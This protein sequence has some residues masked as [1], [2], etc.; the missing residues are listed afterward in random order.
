[1]ALRVHFTSDDLARTRL[2]EGPRPLLELGSA[3]RLLQKTTQ[4]VGLDAWRHRA[5][6]SLNPRVRM[7]F[8]LIPKKGYSAP[9]LTPVDDGSPVVLLEE[10]RRTAPAN[11]R[12][13]L[14]GW[15]EHQPKVPAWI[16]RLGK[17]PQAL[18]GLVDML[19]HTYDELVS[20]YWPQIARL[21][22]AD[23]VVRI[24]HLAE[25]GVEGLLN[26][27]N[28]RIIRWNPPVLELTL[29]SGHSRDVH[30]NGRGL[31]LIPSFFEGSFPA[32]DDREGSQ[33][34]IIFPM[35]HGEHMRI[36][37]PAIAATLT[38]APRSLTA[39]LGRTR[40][41]VLCAIADHPGC[42]TTELARHAGVA[43]ASAS[44]HATVL[45]T[46]G[47]TTTS[48]HRNAVLHALTPAGITLLNASTASPRGCA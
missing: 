34:W 6:I 25:D 3:I 37:S 7:L 17:E 45:R 24:R 8:D 18:Q 13:D 4:T 46:A 23:R 42:T 12:D 26:S 33:P 47:L 1:M 28:P 44:E 9:F 27:L 29:A 10:V 48:R 31:L 2:A 43:P 39:L 40:A 20:P 11:L 22:L 32:M 41:T 14:Q 30:L 36:P 16:H 38:S 15:A 35:R 21:A 5:S 19:G